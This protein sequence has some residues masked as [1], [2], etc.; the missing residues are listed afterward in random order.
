MSTL[1]VC[2]LAG[3]L[4]SRMGQDKRFLKLGEQSLLDRVITLAQ[5]LD[6]ESLL[7]CGEVAGYD[8]LPDQISQ[9]GPISG[10]LSAT[11]ALQKPNWLLV[12]PVDMPL[13]HTDFLKDFLKK[14]QK[15]GIAYQDFELPLLFWCNAHALEIL[16]NLERWSIKA[17]LKALEVKR[18]E[19]DPVYQSC[20]ENL[21]Y[22]EDWERIREHSI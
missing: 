15:P 17:F 16:E 14:A 8:C 18:L 20:F 4:S 12:L 6:P 21:N 7:I 9:K 22:P 3:G 1:V 13:L 2:I 11:R 10:L 19:L 5:S